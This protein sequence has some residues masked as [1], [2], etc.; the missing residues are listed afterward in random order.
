MNL[1][2]A[3]FFHELLGYSPWRSGIAVLLRGFGTLAGMFVI[4]QLARRAFD[5]RWRVG[6]GL[7]LM[8]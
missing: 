2:N 3:L 8:T 4:G 5:T 1:L 6:L 7:L